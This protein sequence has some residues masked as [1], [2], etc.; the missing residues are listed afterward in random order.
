[1]ALLLVNMALFVAGPAWNDL[2]AVQGDAQILAKI[3]QDWKDRQKNVNG[4]RVQ[5]S[6]EAF[7][8]NPDQSLDGSVAAGKYA[9]RARPADGVTTKGTL[10]LTV[11]FQQDRLRRVSDSPY[12]R[13]GLLHKMVDKYEVETIDRQGYRRFTPKEKNGTFQDPN[14]DVEMGKS[15][16]HDRFTLFQPGDYPLA[17]A[18]GVI[19]QWNGEFEANKR[20]R[21][22]VPEKFVVRGKA[23]VDGKACVV[24]RS[25]ANVFPGMFVDLWV[26][27]AN[28]SAILRA[29]YY[30]D[31]AMWYRLEIKYPKEGNTVMPSSWKFESY[32]HVSS[33]PTWRIQRRILQ[34]ELNPAFAADE[35]REPYRPGILV[36]DS[37]QMKKYRVAEDGQTLVEVPMRAGKPFFSDEKVRML[38][39]GLVLL[40]IVLGVY[41]VWRRRSRAA[42]MG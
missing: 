16:S 5:M 35:F 19:P 38:F 10:A 20:W 14:N 24:I 25:Q 1:M 21:L 4:F 33:A 9:D 18:A 13:Y 12:P 17:Y 40:I 39:A 2:P 26:D 34:H 7:Y 29:E 42:V 32:G 28:R 11:D 36:M 23:M 15:R 22:K 30:M 8:A 41:C 37:D 27:P 6:D 31:N 3:V